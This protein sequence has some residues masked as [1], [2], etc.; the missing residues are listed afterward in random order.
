M[1]TELRTY[2]IKRGMMES[3]LRHWRE[4]MDR[5][6]ALGI[7]VEWAGF[8]PESMGTFVFLR[9]FRD[10]EERRRLEQ[11]FYEAEWWR[12]VSEEVMSHVVTW[13]SRLFDTAA[14]RGPDTELVDAQ[15]PDTMDR[16]FL[17]LKG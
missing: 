7:R 1:I 13:E 17:P 11:A 8:D 9:S 4:A 14:A 16:L 15:Q 10:E 3:W 2:T 5:N 12:S 6:I